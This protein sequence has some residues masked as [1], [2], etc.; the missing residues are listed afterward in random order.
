[1]RASDTEE[2]AEGH[3]SSRRWGQGVSLSSLVSETL[4]QCSSS[5]C[6][7]ILNTCLSVQLPLK[8]SSRRGGTRMDS[9]RNKNT[10]V[11]VRANKGLLNEWI[12]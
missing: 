9:V 6:L 4:L 3:T 8:L 7:W 12:C 10:P 5:F 1:M 11:V 2:L